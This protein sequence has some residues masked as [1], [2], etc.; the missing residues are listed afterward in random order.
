MLTWSQELFEPFTTIFSLQQDQLD[1][2]ISY[3]L[4]DCSVFLIILFWTS[5]ILFSIN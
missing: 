3:A 4:V 1:I 2:F 5:P